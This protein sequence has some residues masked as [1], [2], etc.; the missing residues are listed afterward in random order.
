MLDIDGSVNPLV[1]VII[2]TH[3][4]KD[5]VIECIDS[6][7]ESS[8]QPIEAIV[9]DNASD[10]HTAD[11]LEDRYGQ[12]IRLIK[13]KVNLYAGG[14]RNLGADSAGGELLLFIDSDNVVDSEMI[15]NLVG[16]L[17]E[18]R[19][20]NIGL[21]GP[22][23]YYRKDPGRLCWVNSSISLLT[24]RSVFKGVGEEDCGQY[25]DLDL[26]RV[27]HIPNAFMAKR[28]IFR[29]IQGI[30]R[31]YV[32]HYEESDLAEKIKRLGYEI[33]IFPKAK[34]WHN[35]ALGIQLGH[36]SYKIGNLS[37]AYYVVRNRIFF[38]RKNSRGWRLFLFLACFSHIFLAY[39]LAVLLFRGKIAL[40][41]P[42][43][44]GYWDGLFIPL[45]KRTQAA[46]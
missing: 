44:K 32:M 1:S 35:V 7:L 41:R 4:R 21:C 14:G 9:V 10:D 45:S 29:M 16:G 26:I 11:E 40:F 28:D 18:N 22:L 34:I 30:D 17:K 43:L 6:V 13:S 42:A 39:E 5:E 8:Y 36:K 31:D 46:G 20:T 15:A 12:R 24:S 3:N 27:G 2:V 23:T 37:M 19:P 25:K 38:M 33:A